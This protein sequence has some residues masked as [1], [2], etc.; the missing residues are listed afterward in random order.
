VI[1]K[2]REET[3]DEKTEGSSTTVSGTKPGC[4]PHCQSM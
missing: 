3:A 4:P 2:E 1:E